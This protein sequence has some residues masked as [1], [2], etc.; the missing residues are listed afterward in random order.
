MFNRGSFNRLPFNRTS[1]IEILASFSWY[2][3]GEVSVHASVEYLAIITMHGEGEFN[4]SAIREKFG[5]LTWDGLGQMSIG[6]IR[7]RLASI[8]W[9]GE[10]EFKINAGKFHIEEIEVLGPF[11]PGDKIVV[12]TAKL[13]VT[14]NGSTIGYEGEFFELNPGNNHIV[15]TD[16]ASGRTVQVR[17]TYRDK[18]I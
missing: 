4:L 3:E 1:S 12:D 14:K 18:F 7:E 5:S 6:A 10:G 9:D 13:R 11:A 17:I 15:Y 2:G 16:T 8:K